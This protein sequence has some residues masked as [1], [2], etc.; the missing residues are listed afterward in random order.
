MKVTMI[1]MLTVLL[2]LAIASAAMASELANVISS[3]PATVTVTEQICM[4]TCGRATPLSV[5]NALAT[6][7][8]ASAAVSLLSMMADD[9]R[10][11][12]T[13]LEPAANTATVTDALTA[14]NCPAPPELDLS[15]AVF[16]SFPDS[17][18][19]DF[20]STTNI[21]T[22]ANGTEAPGEHWSEGRNSL[23]VTTSSMC[24]S[25]AYAMYLDGWGQE[26]PRCGAGILDNL[27]GQ[28]G[29]VERWFCKRWGTG[30]FV[31]FLLRAPYRVKCALDGVWLASPHDKR[32][33]G[34]CCAYVGDANIKFNVC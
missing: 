13:A 2:S 7:D 5:A 19:G 34:L 17:L 30:V 27:R 26:G 4:D 12:A 29:N 8:D 16:S 20:Y 1:S 32:E 23:C 10:Q 24:Y 6:A 31:T 11:N 22:T 18:N 15:A 3:A 21:N 33:T 14:T 9:Y 28:C 25:G